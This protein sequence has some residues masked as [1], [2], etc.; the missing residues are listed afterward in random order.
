MIIVHV[1]TD[2]NPV[3]ARLAIEA[4][5]GPIMRFE[6]SSDKA[7]SVL[8]IYTDKPRA[9]VAGRLA[10]L[11]EIVLPDMTNPAPLKTDHAAKLKQLNPKVIPTDTMRSAFAKIHS[12]LP[13]GPLH[14]FNPDLF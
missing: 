11:P 14:E 6:I 12:D 1:H 3:E 10:A 4:I 8:A 5:L 2:R 7:P 13:N 9:H